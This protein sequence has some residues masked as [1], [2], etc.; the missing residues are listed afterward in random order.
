MKPKFIIISKFIFIWKLLFQLI[1]KMLTIYSWA[2]YDLCIFLKNSV[3]ET[4]ALIQWELLAE[5][6]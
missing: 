3:P 5:S 4:F 2:L 1:A 6:D